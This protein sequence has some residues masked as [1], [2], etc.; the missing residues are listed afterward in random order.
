M[1]DARRRSIAARSPRAPVHERHGM[2]RTP[3]KRAPGRPGLS[4]LA[5]HLT[6]TSLVARVTSLGLRHPPGPR[7]REGERT[8]GDESDA[9]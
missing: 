9:Q 4:S 8:R 1:P 6:L 3:R 5:R 2:R 7:H